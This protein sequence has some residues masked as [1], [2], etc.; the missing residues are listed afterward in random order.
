MESVSW[1][2]SVHGKTSR[3]TNY[4]A[5]CPFNY[6]RIPSPKLI[7]YTLTLNASSCYYEIRENGIGSS[8]R[9]DTRDPISY[10]SFH[11]F[12]CFE[13][14]YYCLLRI[15]KL[16]EIVMKPK[17]SIKCQHLAICHCEDA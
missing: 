5:R 7:G 9:Y 15:G 13:T 8:Y 3:D 10:T 12:V 16:S 2:E 11:S 4:Y 1:F 17:L 6:S 14:A